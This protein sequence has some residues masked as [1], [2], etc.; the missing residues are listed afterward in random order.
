MIKTIYFIRHGQAESF[1]AS[2]T[3]MDAALSSKG[4]EQCSFLKI[5][6]KKHAPIECVFT[7][8]LTRAKET[9][10]L[11][12]SEI[13]HERIELDELNELHCVGNWRSYSADEAELINNQLLYRPVHA[14]NT[15]E[16]LFDFHERL[17]I[18]INKIFNTPLS[19]IAV[20]CHLAVLNRIMEILFG[21]PKTHDSV[22][23]IRFKHASYTR[24][25][26]IERDPT[27]L[28]FP[29]RLLMFEAINVFDHVTEP[30]R[31]A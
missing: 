23:F 2:E 25:K 19:T 28:E 31:S 7:S 17:N 4:I 29:E 24:I 14:N 18:A 12:F 6:M 27:A 13:N 20:V 10:D 30:L 16:Q 1:S 11:I 8:S 5:E 26:L 15:G 21:L 9:A 3:P 22:T